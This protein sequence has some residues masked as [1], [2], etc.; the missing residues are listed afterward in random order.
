[1]V[2]SL[3]SSKHCLPFFFFFPSFS[4]KAFIYTGGN[5]QSSRSRNGRDRSAYLI[6]LFCLSHIFPSTCAFPSSSRVCFFFSILQV[7]PGG[8][9]SINALM[10]LHPEQNLSRYLP[11]SCCVYVNCLVSYPYWQLMSIS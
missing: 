6:L 2:L 4:E 9:R 7:S 11:P 5:Q 10:L 1:M 3:M 8:W